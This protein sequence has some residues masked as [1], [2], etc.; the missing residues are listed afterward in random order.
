MRKWP[1]LDNLD[2]SI[3]DRV[4]TQEGGV[5]V[6]RATRVFTWKESGE[7]AYEQPAEAHVTI[8]AGEWSNSRCAE[9]WASADLARH[10]VERRQLTRRPAV[11]RERGLPEVCA[12]TIA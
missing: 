10:I 5:F 3:R 11:V 6:S 2:I 4:I 12:V 1:G 7:V 9:R 8:D